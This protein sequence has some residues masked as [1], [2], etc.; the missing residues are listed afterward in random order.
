[1]FDRD[2]HGFITVPGEMQKSKK[3]APLIILSDLTQVLK[4]L[5]DTLSPPETLVFY[6]RE[7]FGNFFFVRR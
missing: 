6:W 1:M 3:V 7:S 4:T 2:G 5:G